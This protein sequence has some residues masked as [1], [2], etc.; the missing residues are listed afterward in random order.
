MDEEEWEAVVREY[1]PR[2]EALRQA[3]G[4]ERWRELWWGE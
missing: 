2:I 4:E 3:V 1:V